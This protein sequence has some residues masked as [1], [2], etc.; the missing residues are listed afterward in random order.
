M[1]V[2]VA[3]AA[4]AR[5]VAFLFISFMIDPLSENPVGSA[6]VTHLRD[7]QGPRRA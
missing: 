7:T 4:M 5:S 1:A 6:D 2:T 3:A